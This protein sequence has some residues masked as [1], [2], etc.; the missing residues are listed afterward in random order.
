MLPA[1]SPGSLRFIAV[2]LLGWSWKHWLPDPM[3]P[4]SVGTTRLLSPHSSSLMC[5]QRTRSPEALGMLTHKLQDLPFRLSRSKADK[6]AAN[7]RGFFQNLSGV[8]QKYIRVELLP[9]NGSFFDTIEFQVNMFFSLGFFWPSLIMNL[10][11]K[12]SHRKKALR[13]RCLSWNLMS[14]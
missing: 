1:L 6:L 14:D 2:C 4:D 8:C 7:Q 5:W 9:Q 13:Y 11:L 3:I 10:V 12:D